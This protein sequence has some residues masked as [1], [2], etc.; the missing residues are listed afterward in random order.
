MSSLLLGKRKSC[1]KGLTTLT[2]IMGLLSR[3]G[4]L[5]LSPEGLPT[6]HACVWLLCTA[7]PLMM[8][9]VGNITKGFSTLTALTGLRPRVNC[10]RLNV[11]WMGTKSF[12]TCVTL[13][14]SFSSMSV[15][16]NSLVL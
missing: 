4:S 1:A 3:M 10:M 15:T 9:Q 11:R 14:E 8:D 13:M 2:T 6:L 16:V 12:L 5:M 7:H